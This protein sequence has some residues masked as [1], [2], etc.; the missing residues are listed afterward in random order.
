M[1]DYQHKATT[2][3]AEG[4][5]PGSQSSQ[6]M[7]TVR[8]CVAERVARYLEGLNGQEGPGR[9]Y[10]MMTA[11]V[12]LPMLREV[13]AYTKDNCC[14]AARIL[15]LNRG[16]LLARLKRYGLDQEIHSRRHR[17]LRGSEGLVSLQ[18]FPSGARRENRH[19]ETY[20][21]RHS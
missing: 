21:E 1:Q 11:E 12:E 16:T 7:P 4:T 6:T 19:S 5:A 17:R 15:G 3:V 2:G 10:R 18:R 13:L 14:Q 9:L 8:A 20:N